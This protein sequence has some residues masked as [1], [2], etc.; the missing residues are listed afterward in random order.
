MTLVL[1]MRWHR[2]V[3]KSTG[4]KSRSRQAGLRQTKILLHSQEIIN[5]VK[6]RPPEGEKTVAS[7]VSEEVNF[8][9][10]YITHNLAKK[11]Q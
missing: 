3:I 5:R 9:N 4:S 8:Q 11:T 1:A 2:C 7:H 6:R 10:I